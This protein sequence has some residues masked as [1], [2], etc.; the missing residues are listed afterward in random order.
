MAVDGI[1]GMALISMERSD[2]PARTLIAGAC[3]LLATIYPLTDAFGVAGAAGAV[4]LG[5]A[6][7]NVWRLRLLHRCLPG[8][9][10]SV[11]QAH[12][13]PVVAGAAAGGLLCWLIART[14]PGIPIGM[15]G[16]VAGSAVAGLGWWL[17]ER[18]A[19]KHDVAAVG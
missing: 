6:T 19:P 16:G 12:L 11:A 7:S 9:L 15:V 3:V 17:G 8:G 13:L 4:A 2:L 10:A 14:S 18:R 5:T 1:S